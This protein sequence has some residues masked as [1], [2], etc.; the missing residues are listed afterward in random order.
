MASEISSYKAKREP[1]N[2]LELVDDLKLKLGTWEKVAK[3]LGVTTRTIRRWRDG[4]RNPDRGKS[5]QKIQQVAKRKKIAKTKIGE[6]NPDRIPDKVFNRLNTDPRDF[7]VIVE[8][9]VTIENKLKENRLESFV[10]AGLDPKGAKK[11]AQ[12][13]ANSIKKSKSQSRKQA[14]IKGIYLKPINPKRNG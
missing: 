4:T 5:K 12:A 3:S 11:Q 14:K 10:V 7:Q 2:S 13:L 8:Y 9:T 1:K 6:I